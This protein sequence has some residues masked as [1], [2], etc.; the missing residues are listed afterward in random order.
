MPDLRGTFQSELVRS[1]V[2]VCYSKPIWMRGVRMAARMK[3]PSINAAIILCCLILSA[4][5]VILFYGQADC[6]RTGPIGSL[7]G[8][9]YPFMLAGLK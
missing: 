6:V 8:T 4:S 5:H 1:A 3:N 2:I 7:L 9:I